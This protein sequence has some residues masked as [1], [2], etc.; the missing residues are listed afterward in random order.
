[1]LGKG[2]GKNKV[3]AGNWAAV[4]A[5]FGECKDVVAD[6]EEKL[7]AIKAERKKAREGK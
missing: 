3:E 7:L 4:R 5:M 2:E 1:M 6:C